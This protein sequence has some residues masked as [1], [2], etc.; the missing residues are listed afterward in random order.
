M[1]DQIVSRVLILAHQMMTNSHLKA[2]VAV[3][4]YNRDRK[5]LS[6]DSVWA[7]GR[8]S[9]LSNWDDKSFRNL[10]EL[11]HWESSDGE[12][13]V[14]PIGGFFMATGRPGAVR[15][16]VGRVHYIVSCWGLGDDANLLLAKLLIYS[17]EHDIILH[18][19]GFG[20]TD[21][22]ALNGAIRQSSA[23]NGVEPLS[24]P[25]DDHERYYVRVFDTEMPF[26]KYWI[27]YQ[28]GPG[29]RPHNVHFDFYCDDPYAFLDA[30][31][32][33]HGG[34]TLWETEHFSPSGV[35]WAIT[36]GKPFGIM[37]RPKWDEIN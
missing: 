14:S 15:R 25:A 1:Y 4:V 33:Y 36:D 32:L 6:G 28:I 9:Q 19:I 16:M 29:V 17:M 18:H 35:V 11:S 12:E 3:A 22:K 23:L 30:I 2:H 7:G 27:E 8:P 5:L 31:G 34:P 24:L 21:R 26:G 10:T 37:A 13:T 20:F